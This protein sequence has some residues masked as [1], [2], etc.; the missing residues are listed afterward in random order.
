MKIKRIIAF[1]LLASML[2][3][4]CACNSDDSDAT[5]GDPTDN[6]PTDNAEDG[7]NED[8]TDKPLLD[9]DIWLSDPDAPV[10]I[11]YGDGAKGAAIKIYDRLTALDAKFTMG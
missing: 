10:R 6:A 11:V 1:L 3:L 8:G 5:V 9:T 4:A 2:L 7:K